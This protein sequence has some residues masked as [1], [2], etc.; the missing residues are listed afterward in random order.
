LNTGFHLDPK[1]LA[2]EKMWKILYCGSGER[3]VAD[4]EIDDG[5]QDACTRKLRSNSQN[6][7]HCQR[8]SSGRSRSTSSGLST[9]Y[10]S[11]GVSE[12]V[13][14]GQCTVVWYRRIDK[15]VPYYSTWYTMIA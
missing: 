6:R 15:C 2:S 7:E 13:E 10:W 14:S 3:S 8:I 9:C 4:T 11:K 12:W 5:R 1:I